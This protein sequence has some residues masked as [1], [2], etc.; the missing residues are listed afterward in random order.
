[1]P[2][3]P[4]HA[5]RHS[6]RLTAPAAEYGSTG[7]AR[8]L[9]SQ[10]KPTGNKPAKTAPPPSPKATSADAARFKVPASYS[11]KNWDPTESPILLLGNAFDANSLGKW[12]YDWTVFNHGAGTPLSETASDL[13]RLLLKLT[14]KTNQAPRRGRGRRRN[15]AYYKIYNADNEKVSSIN[16]LGKKV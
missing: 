13:W 8:S 11:L 6:R 1:M 9:E 4:T 14:Y 5:R 16:K 2:Y 10:P 12:I 15:D 3:M 7:C